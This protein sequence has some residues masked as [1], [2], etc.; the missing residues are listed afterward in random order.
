MWLFIYTDIG[1]TSL[2]KVASSGGPDSLSLKIGN[3][4]LE[5]VKVCSTEKDLSQK[6]SYIGDSQS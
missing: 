3:P 4:R 5:K 6:Q 1:Q 2:S